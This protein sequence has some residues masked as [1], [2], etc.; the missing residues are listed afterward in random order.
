VKET[1]QSNASLSPNPPKP[2]TSKARQ[3]DALYQGNRLAARVRD[4]EVDL[5]AKEIRFGEISNSDELMIPE[6]CEF[7]K[8]RIQIQRI[9]YA[10]K[11]DPHEPDK[12][13]IL[14]GVCA[15]LL[16]FREQ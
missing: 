12:G 15:D 2:A 5:D 10:S 14:R 9:A 7:Q 8:Y 16:G 6:E 1:S 3:S 13:R 11:L 4:V